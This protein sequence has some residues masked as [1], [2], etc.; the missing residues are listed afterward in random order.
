VESDERLVYQIID[1]ARTVHSALGPGFL[2]SIYGRAL[3]A[4]LKTKGFQVEREKQIKI[5]YATSVVGKH[6]LDLV[7]GDVVVVEL[8]ANRGI[9][10]VHT[11]QMNSYLH[12]TDYPFGVILNFGMP[13]LEWE[14][15][16]SRQA[17]NPE[18]H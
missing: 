17:G 9:V 7:V 18:F 6:R 11:A 12:A 1:A 4:E 13:E 3:V 5:W 14:M 10:H 8:K 2:E 15:I 16:S